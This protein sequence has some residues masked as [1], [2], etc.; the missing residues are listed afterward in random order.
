MKVPS[1]V[2]SWCC[3]VFL[4]INPTL[5]MNRSN[6]MARRYGNGAR[7]TAANVQAVETIIGQV[8][9]GFVPKQDPFRELAMEIEV[10]SQS[11]IMTNKL[12]FPSISETQ[13]VLFFAMILEMLKK[14][15]AMCR[16]SRCFQ[17]SSKESENQQS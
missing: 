3:L 17:S 8:G 1:L 2:L 9:C 11:V 6:N 16:R 15:M 13:S 7:A 4:S 14:S 5:G 10:C 12:Y